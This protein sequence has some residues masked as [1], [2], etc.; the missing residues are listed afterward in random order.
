MR[1]ALFILAILFLSGHILHAQ[2]DGNKSIRWNCNIFS[3]DLKWACRWKIIADN[4]YTEGTIIKFDKQQGR[5]GDEYVAAVAI[6]KRT[7]DTIRAILGCCNYIFYT[8]DYVRIKISAPPKVS[9]SIPVDIPWGY[10]PTLRK[11]RVIQVNEYDEAVRKTVFGTI[12][13]TK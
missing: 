1:S 2:K 6:I 7:E 9:I 13:R 12:V 8:G 11:E 5:C 3:E 10:N 4:G